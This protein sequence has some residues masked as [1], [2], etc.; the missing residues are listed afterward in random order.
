MVVG[1]FTL[2]TDTVHT[3]LPDLRAELKRFNAE[4]EAILGGMPIDVDSRMPLPR[5]GVGGD[6]EEPQ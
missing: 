6:V 4:R 5:S 2:V 1:Y 3:R